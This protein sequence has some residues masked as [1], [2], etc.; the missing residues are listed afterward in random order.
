MWPEVSPAEHAAG[1]AQQRQHVAIADRGTPELDAGA[2]A[3]PARAQGCSSRCPPP[4]RAALPS[5]LAGARDDVEQLVTVDD[6]AEVIDHDEPV[7]VAVEG[8]ADVGA[9]AG[10]RELQQIRRESSRS[11]H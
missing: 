6:A 4:G 11:R 8:E 5:L 3:A 10:H 1:L 2:R 9:H 7:A